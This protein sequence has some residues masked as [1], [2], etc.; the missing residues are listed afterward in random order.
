M[1]F[2]AILLAFGA[3]IL[4]GLWAVFIDLASSQGVTAPM[5]V[6][7]V[8][9][10]AA[11]VGLAW[12]M[13]AHSVGDVTQLISLRPVGYVLIAG[14][15]VGLGTMLYYH[16]VDIGNAG[17]MTAIVG[18]YF[19]IPSVVGILLWGQG[20]SLQTLGGITLAGTAVLLM[21]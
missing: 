5:L 18:L 14:L 10:I 2:G 20:V 21:A 11:L 16:S 8:N 3:M 15:A 9:G 13:T 19:I 7:V 1:A 17:T 12:T 6:T 4:W